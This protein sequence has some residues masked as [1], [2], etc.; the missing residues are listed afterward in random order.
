ML[1][2][3][4]GDTLR[5][6]RSY[7]RALSRQQERPFAGLLRSPLTDSNRRPPPYHG[8]AGAVG[9]SRA[10]EKCG[11]LNPST[12]YSR[13]SLATLSDFC[14]PQMLHESGGI[15]SPARMDE[16]G[17][18]IETG[19]QRGRLLLHRACRTRS[20][21][22]RGEP[23]RRRRSPRRPSQAPTN[24]EAK[25]PSTTAREPRGGRERAALGTYALVL[26]DRLGRA[27]RG[28]RTERPTR[29]T[30]RVPSTLVLRGRRGS[31]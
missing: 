20:P 31:R 21:S 13:S 25:R 30:S 22:R 24:C 2:T 12:W 9:R 15:K 4:L 6:A 7:V 11:L 26:V 28:R 3:D 29:G 1:G 23:R 14:V 19:L 27:S 8:F 16:S 10:Q 17:W 5:D 18:T